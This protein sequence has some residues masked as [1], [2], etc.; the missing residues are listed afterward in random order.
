MLRLAVAGLLLTTPALAQEPSAKPAQPQPGRITGI[1]VTDGGALVAGATVA[2]TSDIA[3][4]GS[5]SA[6]VSDPSG[7]FDFQ[8]E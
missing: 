4:G 2:L 8:G 1:V 5:Q 3:N 6:I 7:G